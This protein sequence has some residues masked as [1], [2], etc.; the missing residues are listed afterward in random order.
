MLVFSHHTNYPRTIAIYLLQR[1]GFCIPDKIYLRWLYRLKMGRRL[2]LKHPKF[3]NEKLQWLKLYN[4]KP[5]HI[6]MVDKYAAKDHVANIIG[7]EYIIP[8]LGVWDKFESI[9]WDKLPNQFVLKTTHDGGSYGV[10]ICKDKTTFNKEDAMTK[11]NRSLLRSTYKGGREWPYKD[12]KPRIICEKYLQPN[13]NHMELPD[14]KWFCFNGEP[15][16]C[17]VIQDRHSNETIDFFD[18]SWNHQEFIGL[19]PISG[20]FLFNAATPP[21]CPIHLKTQIE[22]ARKLSKNSLFSRIDLYE[23]EDRVYFGE[24]TFFPMSGFGVFL[25]ARYNEILGNMI[26]LPKKNKKCQ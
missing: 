11:L 6:I 24:I 3:F 23:T 20:P 5:E 22:I 10:V 17:Q 15:E 4:R 14:Y 21:K 19:V 13:P 2:D 1:L 8:T 7:K 25:P 26:T 18:T 16:F 12:V 9:D